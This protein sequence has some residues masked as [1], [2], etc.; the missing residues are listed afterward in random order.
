MNEFC[1]FLYDFTEA[2]KEDLF[3]NKQQERDNF[4]VLRKF[5]VFLKKNGVEKLEESFFDED[6]SELLK[7]MNE[8]LKSTELSK[9]SVSAI[10]RMATKF[11]KYCR[12]EHVPIINDEERLEHARKC[13]VELEELENEKTREENEKEVDE[14]SNERCVKGA[15]E[16]NKGK[17]STKKRKGSEESQVEKR[18]RRK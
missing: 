7:K 1:P 3:S 8:E 11:L 17:E 14:D 18:K 2:R 12:D 5:F 6:R 4:S 16:S 10:E 15:S 13:V 9:D